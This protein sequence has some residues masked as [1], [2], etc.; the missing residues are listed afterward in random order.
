MGVRGRRRFC[1]GCGQSR[2]FEKRQLNWIL[3][4]LLFVFTGG[5]WFFVIMFLLI[6]QNFTPFRC[7]ECG[8]AR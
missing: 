8:R 2:P 6:G 1:K 5:L 3:H 7:R 4:L